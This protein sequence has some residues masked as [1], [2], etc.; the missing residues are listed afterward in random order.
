M[1]AGHMLLLM[2]TTNLAKNALV[3]I[4]EMYVLAEIFKIAVTHYRIVI[5]VTTDCTLCMWSMCSTEL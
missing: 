2:S 1:H 5:S 4:T 3:K